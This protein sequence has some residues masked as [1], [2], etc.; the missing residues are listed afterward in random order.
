M[1][2]HESSLDPM[3]IVSTE[4]RSV[5]HTSEQL[6]GRWMVVIDSLYAVE[7]FN[8]AMKLPRAKLDSVAGR[9]R[10]RETS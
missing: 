3:Q 2:W 9:R 8:V 7:S 10:C 1:K 4:E 6:T 5:S